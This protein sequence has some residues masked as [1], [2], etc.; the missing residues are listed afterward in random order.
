MKQTN[1][2]ETLERR[3]EGHSTTSDQRMPSVGH[4]GLSAGK[5]PSSGQVQ[6]ITSA[7]DTPSGKSDEIKSALAETGEKL[8]EKAGEVGQHAKDAAAQ[9]GDHLIESARTKVRNLEEAAKRASTKLQDEQPSLVTDG[10]DHLAS[11][12]SSVASYLDRTDARGLV[13][14]A[15]DLAVARP[16]LVLGSLAAVGFLVGRFLKA[17]PVEPEQPSMEGGRS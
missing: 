8:R 14:D 13:D 12:L 10:V 15:R 6:M 16:A 2:T 1:N 5:Q 9:R 7:D 4:Q 11:R 17:S 3:P